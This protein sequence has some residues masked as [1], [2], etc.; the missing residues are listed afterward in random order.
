MRFL[1][2]TDLEHFG[3]KKTFG[4]RE[5]KQFRNDTH[6]IKHFDKLIESNDFL[7]DSLIYLLVGSNNKPIG[8]SC[9]KFNNGLF[10]ISLVSVS[11]DLPD[12]YYEKLIIHHTL[13]ELRKK[14]IEQVTTSI[15]ELK[16]KMMSW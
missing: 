8:I 16:D 4:L 15:P 5:I 6:Q 3:N 2:F 10:N 9:I 7:A 13:S 14:G 11:K 1:V 12:N